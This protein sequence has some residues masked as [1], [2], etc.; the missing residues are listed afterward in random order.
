MMNK[1]Y[2][3]VISIVIRHH[4]KPLELR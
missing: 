4:Q 1:V 3:P 2:K